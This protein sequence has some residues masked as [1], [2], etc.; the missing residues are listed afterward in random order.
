MDRDVIRETA[1]RVFRSDDLVADE[2]ALA[3]AFLTAH[4]ECGNPHVVRCDWCHETRTLFYD[5]NDAPFKRAARG[6][7]CETC[8][9]AASS[10]EV[11]L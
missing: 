4:P 6:W 11:R 7:L 5:E 3:A 9:I 1:G 8:D 10:Q 2:K